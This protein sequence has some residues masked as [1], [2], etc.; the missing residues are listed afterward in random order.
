M[1]TYEVTRIISSSL[2]EIS[3]LN[4]TRKSMV[5]TINKVKILP[6]TDASQGPE[7][8]YRMKSTLMLFLHPNLNIWDPL[9]LL[10]LRQ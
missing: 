2:I 10:R 4:D 3:K 9:P 8:P 5:V 6:N 1:S 7:L